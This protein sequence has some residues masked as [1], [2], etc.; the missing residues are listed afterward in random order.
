M[1]EQKPSERALKIGFWILVVGTLALLGVIA[2]LASL[3]LS[4]GA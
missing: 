4:M 2:W 3:V 1:D